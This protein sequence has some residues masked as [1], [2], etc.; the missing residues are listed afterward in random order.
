VQSTF[1]YVNRKF[2]E[3]Y[4]PT[5]NLAVD[6]SLMMWKESLS[7]AQFI[8]INKARLRIKTYI[9]SES[10]SRYIWNMTIYC[11]KTTELKRSENVGHASKVV[12]TLNEKL[13]D[14]SHT[15][16]VDN[17]YSSPELPLSLRQTD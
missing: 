3:V 11:V 12:L 1:E 17:F 5:Q 4:T 6:E 16:Y 7:I 8:H 2:S 15:M 13:L 10:Q 14:K 9:L